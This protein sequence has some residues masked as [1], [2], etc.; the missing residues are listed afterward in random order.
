M[1]DMPLEPAVVGSPRRDAE[2]TRGELLGAARRR[3]ARDGY[4]VTTVRAIAGDAGVNIALISRYFGSKEGLFAA[5]MSQTV[6]QIGPRPDEHQD[7][8]EMVGALVRRVAEA[9]AGDDALQLLLL[10]RS[11]GDEA[12]D[13]IRRDTLRSFAA[14]LA[15]AARRGMPDAAPDDLGM[16][17]QIALA[18]MLGIVMLRVSGSLEPLASADERDLRLPL[19]DMFGAL[20]DGR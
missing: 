4:R 3:F 5:C 11:S 12:A 1:V 7:L 13:R 9:P 2:H 18:T 6:E 8:D 19:H 20:L 16:R 17:A 14:R 15:D 10:L